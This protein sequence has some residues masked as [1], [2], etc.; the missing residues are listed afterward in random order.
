LLLKEP[1]AK[2]LFPGIFS[3]NAAAYKR[4]LD[5]LTARGEARGRAAVMDW[6][7][8]AAGKR[9]LDL[10]CGPGTLTLQ[11]AA[12]VGPDGSVV[13]IDLA[14]GMIEEATRAMIPGLPVRFE[15]MDIEDLRFPDACFDAAVSGHSL[16][17]CPDLA[18]ALREA[19]RVLAPG[20]RLAAS[21]PVDPLRPSGPHGVLD[22]ATANDLPAMP[23][24]SDQAGTRRTVSD[25][26]RFATAARDAGFSDVR[27]Q[28]IEEMTTWP[29]AQHFVDM[30][31]S[32]WSMAVRLEQLTEAERTRVLLRARQAIE[33][34]LGPGPYR[35]KGAT[36]VLLAMT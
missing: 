17:F 32:W 20:S 14:A 13:G 8:P 28:L 6:V 1:A 19:R 23:R 25:P 16:Q 30:A 11:L 5:E 12:A 3:R 26:E 10:G 15:L 29:T 21:V 2:E 4:R 18:R 34:E 35:I 27:V 9:I 33:S 24:A 36:S 31:S 7:Q 22:R